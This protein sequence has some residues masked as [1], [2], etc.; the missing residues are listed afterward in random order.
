ML[1]YDGKGWSDMASGTDTELH[2]VWGTSSSDVFA[3]GSG[4]VI[5]HY[6]GNSWTSMPSGTASDLYGVWGSSSSDVFVAGTAGAVLHY[7]GQSWNPTSSISKSDYF[8]IWESP[9]SEVFAVG[10]GGGILHYDGKTWS[11]MTSGTATVLYGVWGSSS[12]D[13][14]AVGGR[15][16]ILHYDGNKWSA[17]TSGTTS[18]LSGVWGR[19]SSDVV[20]V[21]TSGAILHYDGKKWSTMTSGTV[22]DIY[23]V[24]GSSSSDVF[25]V[26]SNGVILHYGSALDSI[27]SNLI[28]QVD[29]SR[30]L[31]TV[32]ALQNFT[33]RV[34]GYPGNTRAATYLYSELSAIPGLSVEYQSNYKNVVATLPGKDSIVYMVGAHYDSE[35]QDPTRSPGATDDGAGCGIVLELARIMSHY[36]Y[37]HTL[38]FAFWNDEEDGS[39]GSEAYVSFINGNHLNLALYHNFDSAA[40]DPNNQFSLDVVSNS[41]QPGFRTFWPI[42]TPFTA[43]ISP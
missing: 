20:T 8:D 25:A 3:V 10:S 9:S 7:D 36:S 14:F 33:S 28:S 32:N 2:D 24:W 30:I 5:L 41:N 37:D 12:S 39:L 38:K 15:G 23:G 27:I 13:V 18:E 29:Q 26:G 6:D 31:E 17:M 40:Y 34:Y 16:T 19:P 21:G 11:V 43:S 42:I 35:S 1:H 22:S 4:G